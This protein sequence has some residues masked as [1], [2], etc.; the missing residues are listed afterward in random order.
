MFIRIKSRTLDVYANFSSEISLE[1]ILLL[2]MKIA[3]F[4]KISWIVKK[5]EI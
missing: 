5:E 3:Q 4:T 2:I 1:F